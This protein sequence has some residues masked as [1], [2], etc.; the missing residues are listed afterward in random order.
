MKLCSVW[1]SLLCLS[2][3]TPDEIRAATGRELADALTQLSV[4]SE[5]TFRVRDVTLN[6]GGA[7]FFL[8]EGVL[9]FTKP[10]EGQTIA[11][12]FTTEGVEAGDAELILLPP[13][14]SE[15]T[16]L[17][18]FTS[19]ANLNEHFAS[20]LFF[21][22]DNTK[23][24]LLSQA[25][26]GTI[27]KAPELTPDLQRR[28]APSLRSAGG[29]LVTRTVE[30]LLD[31]HN[32]ESG[33]FF[34]V[35][36]GR[37][38]GV[39]DVLYQP[40]LLEP[41]AVGRLA[42]SDDRRRSFQLWTAYRPRQSAPYKREPVQVEDFRADVNIRSDLTAELETT[43]QYRPLA[44]GSRVA[45]FA[46]SR[47]L[48]ITSATIG[49]DPVE[50]LQRPSAV[51]NGPLE[52]EAS[53]GSFLL[54]RTQPFEVGRTYP[55]SVR[56]AGPLI[57]KSERQYLVSERSS[58]LPTAGPLFTNF[59]LT[60]HLPA[61]LRVVATGSLTQEKT[62]GGIRTAQFVTRT[63]EHFAGF[64][65][66]EYVLHEEDRGPYRVRCS[67]NQ[68]VSAR[69][70]S[71]AIEAAELLTLFS[72]RWGILPFRDVSISPIPANLGQGFPGLIYLSS[73]SYL[74]ETQRPSAL[75]GPA[76]DLFFSG[77]LLPHETAHQWW[78][79][80]VT[81]EDYRTDWLMEAMANY[82][83]VQVLERREGSHAVAKLLETYQSDLL[84]ARQDGSRY[85]AAGAVVLGSRLLES[86]DFRTWQ[87]IVYEKGTW[88]IH[89]LRRRLGDVKFLELQQWIVEHYSRQPISNDELRQAASRF[90][91]AGQLDRG[92]H[93]FFEAWVFGTGIPSLSLHREQSETSIEMRGVDPD[94]AVD[95]PLTCSEGG[96][97]D[98]HWIRAVSGD[99]V[100][101]PSLRS[102]SL[103]KAEDFL[104]AR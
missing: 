19:A 102:C 28:W 45:T 89:M 90:I 54:I 36:S 32:P 56:Y 3:L 20:A 66:G 97:Q 93:D 74:D 76:M 11:A 68:G 35:I 100:L 75:Q 87:V 99:T 63:P 8:T 41:I 55:I 39:F 104:Y 49:G 15:R 9:A 98:V 22:S 69:T 95:V 88:I 44:R 70:R 43:F 13:T 78:G 84:R 38:L 51:E 40:P 59:D 26:E 80:V 73:N 2:I 82:S 46:L 72:N 31:N 57:Q 60:F 48:A 37:S 85:E 94:F 61:R 101:K 62:S 6:R 83:A 17:A 58:W 10:V 86:Y 33:E 7:K 4:D 96:R 16:S 50:V 47:R 64:N 23:H 18:H 1:I 5:N 42:E 30:H 12:V 79:N 25:E 77:M 71:I 14:R 103:P 27:Q 52:E 34:A 65:I 81:P 67:S 21:F 24:D 29:D 92:L 53:R 91:P